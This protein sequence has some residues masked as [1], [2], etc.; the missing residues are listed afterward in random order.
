MPYDFIPPLKDIY[1]I[2]PIFRNLDTLGNEMNNVPCSRLEIMLHLDIQ[3]G[4]GYENVFISK[5]SRRD[6][7]V[8][9]ETS[10]G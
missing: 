3:R 10:D 5:I 6:C 8:H 7:L 2:T 4:G 9:E 1:H